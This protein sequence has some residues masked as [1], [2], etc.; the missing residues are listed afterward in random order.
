[1][2]TPVETF[3]FG[4]RSKR[5]GFTRRLVP[6]GRGGF[7]RLRL[8][9]PTQVA[10]G[11]CPGSVWAPSGLC[12]GSVRAP[13]GLRLD[14]VWTPSGLRL[15]SVWTPSGLRLG[16]V[17]APSGLGRAGPDGLLEARW[18]PRFQVIL[19]S[20][21]GFSGPYVFHVSH[22]RKCV[23]VSR[24]SR[25]FTFPIAGRVTCWRQQIR[26][27]QNLEAPVKE[28]KAGRTCVFT[29]FMFPIAGRVTLRRQ[30]PRKTQKRACKSSLLLFMD[31]QITDALAG[32]KKFF[33]SLKWAA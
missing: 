22:R 28:H 26:K 29:Y 20:V 7:H 9:P 6:G 13:S 18:R 25:F 32:S 15:D 27:T 30:K 2:E 24:V 31:F 17:W 10:F 3:G 1:M 5:W 23:F 8:M 14:S 33:L 16:S 12:L 4:L 21:Y 19:A 11:L